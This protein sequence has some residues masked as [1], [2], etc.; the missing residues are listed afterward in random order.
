[1]TEEEG[2]GSS[3]IVKGGGEPVPKFAKP[4][5]ASLLE[6]WVVKKPA[7]DK[8]VQNEKVI[9]YWTVKFLD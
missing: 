8:A 3:R 5:V 1:M 2:T 7:L 4:V 6:Q 9:L